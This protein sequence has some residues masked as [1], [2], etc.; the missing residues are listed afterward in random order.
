MVV[1]REVWVD[2]DPR[3]IEWVRGRLFEMWRNYGIAW[4][5]DPSF[6]GMTPAEGT[7]ARFAQREAMA[8]GTARLFI[9]G[10]PAEVV[11]ELGPIVEAGASGFAFR[12][13]FD[14]VGGPELER[15]MEQLAQDVV[16]QLQRITR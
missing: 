9:S 4:V 3:R 7:E 15:C 10:S 12:I 6:R 2:R 11:D 14:G 13:R 16:P 1:F 5:D 8:H